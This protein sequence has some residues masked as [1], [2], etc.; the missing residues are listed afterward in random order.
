MYIKVLLQHIIDVGFEI[1]LALQKFD[2][3]EKIF[4]YTVQ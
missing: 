2:S 4:Y 3:K 1:E